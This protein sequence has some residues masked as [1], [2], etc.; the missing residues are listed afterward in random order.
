MVK[1]FKKNV[2]VHTGGHNRNQPDVHKFKN[3]NTN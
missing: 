2:Y 1:V 3:A